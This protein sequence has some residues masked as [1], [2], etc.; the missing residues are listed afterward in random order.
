MPKMSILDRVLVGA[1]TW[2]VFVVRVTVA[3][4][5]AL[6]SLLFLLLLLRALACAADVVAAVAA[7]ARSL[8]Q[9]FAHHPSTELESDP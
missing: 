7:A 1:V 3:I 4:T 6:L 2:K 5:T 8:E 9:L